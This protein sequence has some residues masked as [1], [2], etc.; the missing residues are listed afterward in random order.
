MPGISSSSLTLRPSIIS[1]SPFG[2][3]LTRHSQQVGIVPESVPSELLPNSDLLS[4]GTNI[5]AQDRLAPNWLPTA[6]SS[7]CK[8]PVARFV[9]AAEFSPFTQFLQNSWMNRHW[10]L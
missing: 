9:V 8:H 7:A 3:P 5:L 4:G 1:R 2:S 6:M 10:L